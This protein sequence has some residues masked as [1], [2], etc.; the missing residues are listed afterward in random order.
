VQIG[1][2][3]ALNSGA[4]IQNHLFEDRIMKS[5]DLR[6]DDGCSVGNMS[7]VLYDSH[8]Q[9]GAVLGPLSLLMKGEIVPPATRWHG[10]PT[11]KSFAASN[12]N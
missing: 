3:V 10:I 8:M 5:S 2:C 1:D 6:I 11:V 12:R 7:V 4:V 9:H